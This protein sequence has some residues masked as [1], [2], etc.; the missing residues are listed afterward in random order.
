MPLT[1]E[2]LLTD[3][4]V[5]FCELG[6]R[7]GGA[8]L[9]GRDCPEGRTDQQVVYTFCLGKESGLILNVLIVFVLVMR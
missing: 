4:Q 9:E 7:G 3:G 5:L 8:C 1:N 6:Y 2:K